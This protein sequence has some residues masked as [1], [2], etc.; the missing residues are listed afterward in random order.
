MKNEHICFANNLK[1]LRLEAGYSRSTLAKMISYSEKSIEKWEMTGAIPPVATVCKLADIFGVSVDKL[2]YSSNFEIKYLL[3]IDGGGTKTEF[4][5]TDL[6]GEKIDNIILGSSNPVDIGIENSLNLL[7]RG[8]NQICK[9]IRKKEIS[10]FAGL[11]GGST[12]NNKKE[13]EEF[14]ST[15]DFGRVANGSDTENALEL[16]LG[17]DGG[18]AVIMGTGI[19]ALAE[20]KG[21]RKR[22]GGWGYLIDKGGSGFNFGSDALDSALKAFDGRGGSFL[23]KD[24]IEE[25]LGKPLNES[26]GDIYLKGKTYIASFA[27]CVF[28]AFEQGDQ[29]A[30]RIIERNVEEVAKI[31]ISA[32]DF[33]EEKDVKIVICGGLSNRKEILSKFFDKFLYNDIKIIFNNDAMVKGAAALA[34]KNI[35]AEEN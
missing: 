29:E 14:L 24:L 5:L 16:A 34:R 35:N 31:I 22:V 19:I 27:E 26:I 23:L 7:R 11:S 12:G 13:I 4:L 9:G 8:I 25:K 33:F 10:V 32:Y 20:N 18:V 30:A 2:I 3:G 6:N 21:N 1:K 15:Q 28:T 17:G